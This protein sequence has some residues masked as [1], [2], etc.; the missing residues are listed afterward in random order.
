MSVTQLYD[1]LMHRRKL[2]L[3]VDFNFQRHALEH[4]QREA[5]LA[6]GRI[7]D[8]LHGR[9]ISVVGKTFVLCYSL[10]ICVKVRCE[11]FGPPKRATLDPET[12]DIYINANESFWLAIR[13]PDSSRFLRRLYHVK[14]S[15]VVSKQKYA[16]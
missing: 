1:L 2:N 13:Q 6:A 10:G 3:T 9:N 16:I 4:L 14:K 12:D 5:K 11:T 7:R 8:L 15:I